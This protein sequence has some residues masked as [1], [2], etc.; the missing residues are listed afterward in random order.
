MSRIIQVSVRRVRNLG[1]YETETLEAVAVVEENDIASD[2]A[3]DLRLWVMEQLGIDP[4]P[5]EIPA[6]LR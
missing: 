6:L 3:A 2:V 5:E 1:H 4:Q